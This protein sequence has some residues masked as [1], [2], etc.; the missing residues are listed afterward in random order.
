MQGENA[1]KVP[2]GEIVISNKGSRDSHR[3]NMQG[4]SWKPRIWGPDVLNAS[5]LFA[6]I[7]PWQIFDLSEPWFS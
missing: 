7:V 4:G 3:G 5:L 6:A 1:L 2:K